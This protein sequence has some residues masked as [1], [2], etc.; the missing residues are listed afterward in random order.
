MAA[1]TAHCPILAPSGNAFFSTSAPAL[2]VDLA[3]ACTRGELLAAVVTRPTVHAACHP[4]N[5]QLQ[6]RTK[7]PVLSAGVWC[8][9]SQVLASLKRDVLREH[10]SAVSRVLW[11]RSIVLSL[12]THER[13][14]RD[15]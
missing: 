15:R 3:A 6:P 5:T 11:D 12:Y 7:P 1:F 10:L 4:H 14:A 2:T 8:S 9:R 13:K